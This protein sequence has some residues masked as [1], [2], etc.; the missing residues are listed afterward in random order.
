MKKL[1]SNLW[2]KSFYM[3]GLG[4]AAVTGSFLSANV[5]AAVPSTTTNAITG[6]YAQS[7]GAARIIDAQGGDSCTSS[8]NTITWPASAPQ[9]A[10]LQL[11][12]DGTLDTSYSK[13]IETVTF[14]PDEAQSYY[15]VCVK[16]SFDPK[17]GLSDSVPGIILKTTSSGD[18]V[19]SDRCG[20]DTSYNAILANAIQY[21]APE[22]SHVHT[23]F[24]N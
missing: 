7:G 14:V 3:T 21:D 10:Y 20:S 23:T 1:L 11:N 5:H 6:C 12:S 18:E 8:E 22:Y 19:I 24:F 13:N 4:I 15:S 16:V 17:A 9:I 2:H